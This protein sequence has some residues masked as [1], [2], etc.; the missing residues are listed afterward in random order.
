MSDKLL[1]V[2]NGLNYTSISQFFKDLNHVNFPTLEI[3][4]LSNWPKP[5]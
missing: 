3:C 2:L 4:I 5:S 1:G